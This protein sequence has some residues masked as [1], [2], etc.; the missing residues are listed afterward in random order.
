MVLAA[1]VGVP[2]WHSPEC[3]ESSCAES[4]TTLGVAAARGIILNRGFKADLQWWQFLIHKWNGVIFLQPRRQTVSITSD[5][6]GSWGCGAYPSPWWFQLPWPASMCQADI[7]VK[8]LV[9]I[10][11]A[12]VT[13]GPLFRGAVTVTTRLWWLSST[14]G[15]H[16]THTCC[17]C[18][19]ACFCLRPVCS[20]R[21]RPLISREGIMYWQMTY[22][23]R[24]SSLSFHRHP[25]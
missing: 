15:T 19:V 16:V 2:G 17:I 5:V 20:C 9:P 8:E 12:V 18:C 23:V 1:G 7:A 10:I 6:S 21:S 14:P 13:W 22:P 4:R 25:I 11:L 3:N 24:N